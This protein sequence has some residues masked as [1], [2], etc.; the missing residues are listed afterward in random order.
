MKTITKIWLITAA[1]LVIVGSIIFVAV[2]WQ[3]NWDFSKLNTVKHE[4][5]I[6]KVSE[7]FKNLSVKTDVADIIL[8]LSD[9]EECRVECYEEEKAKHSVTVEDDTLV[10]EVIDKKQWYDYI[11]VNFGSSKITVYLPKVVYISLSV[12]ESTGDV[13]IPK[14][15]KFDDVD[16]SSSTGNVDFV[17]SASGSVKI[18]T[19]T[20]NILVENTSSGELC[21]SSSTGSI[22]A[23]NVICNGDIKT[24]ISTGK[25]NLTDIKCKNLNST[26]STGDIFLNNVIAEEKFHIVRSTGDITFD[27]SDA[28]D[29]F[30]ETDTGDIAGSL[31][32]E[33]VFITHTDTGEIDVP[34]TTYGGKCEINTDTGDIRLTIK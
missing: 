6:H 22:K 2:M 34:K 29:I 33:K 23:S 5:N 13:K 14:E 15:F 26:G 12:K 10:I 32:S 21:L 31:L 25:T 16:I 30:A 20:G 1:S 17:A 4:T 11:G 28:A 8:A 27:S 19:S 7:D 18:K 9:D 3:Y 24:D